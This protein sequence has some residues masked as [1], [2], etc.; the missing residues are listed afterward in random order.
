MKQTIKL[1]PRQFH[2]L[3]TF[4]RRMIKIEQDPDY[5]TE[6]DSES[7]DEGDSNLECETISI[8]KRNGFFE[9]T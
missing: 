2:K 3:Q 6:S 7:S 8:I 4:M 1:T 5:S 9:I